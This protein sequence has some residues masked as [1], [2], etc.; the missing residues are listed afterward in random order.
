[1]GK[2]ASSEWYQNLDKAPWTPPRWTFGAAWT[3]IMIC[4]SFY[5]A[6]AWINTINKNYLILLFAVQWFLNVAWNPTFFYY[7]FSLAGLVIILSLTVLIG[8]L[9]I[10]N[11]PVLKVKTLWIVPYFL[12]LLVATSLNG[13]I[14]FHN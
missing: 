9:M 11:F 13:Y 10:Y 3:I 4:F 2:G 14:L 5:M 7:H 6:T 12:W 8:Y 1:M